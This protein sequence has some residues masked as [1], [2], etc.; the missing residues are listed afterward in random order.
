MYTNNKYL[1]KYR[2]KSTRL[3]NYNYGANGY[4]FVTICTQD[5]LH[6]F[7]EII[8]HKMVYN[9]VG[10][11]AIKFWREI[12]KH[13]KYIEMD[14][15][16]VMPNHVHGV[17]RI[18]KRNGGDVCATVETRKCLVST[19]SSI[20]GSYKSICTKIINRTF[21][22]TNFKWQSRFYDEI[23]KNDEH[24]YNVRQYIKNN[25]TTKLNPFK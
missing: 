16:I 15:F 21:S 17:I 19:I 9:R 3:P 25:P 13:F 12:P 11:L 2:I 5:G 8:N 6:Y 20:I 4:Y 10:Y 22:A 7:G 18:N 14:A 1:D 24:L 23:I